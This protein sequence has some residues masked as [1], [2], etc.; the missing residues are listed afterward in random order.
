MVA[1]EMGRR[2]YH[3]VKIIFSRRVVVI[4]LDLK[5]E[6]WENS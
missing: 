3:L 5:L 2:K 6:S 4:L 1:L